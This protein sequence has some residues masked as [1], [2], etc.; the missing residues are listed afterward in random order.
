MCHRREFPPSKRALR[1]NIDETVLLVVI[2]E[3]GEN[4]NQC[5][6]QRNI[7]GFS[8]GFACRGTE[9][10][11]AKRGRPEF[12]GGQNRRAASG[13]A[14]GVGTNTTSS[15]VTAITAV[16]G[17]DTVYNVIYTNFYPT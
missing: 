12:C 9:R 3:Q 15:V 10:G 6:E 4:R 11:R 13:G 16:I 17:F 7:F 1:A 14:A 5:E 8:H 2:T